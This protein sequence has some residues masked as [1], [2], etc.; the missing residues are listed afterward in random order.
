MKKQNKILVGLVI[1]CVVFLLATLVSVFTQPRERK[2]IS[3]EGLSPEQI[4]QKHLTETYQE[5]NAG[6]TPWN[7]LYFFDTFGERFRL[8]FTWNKRNRVFNAILFHQEKMK[9]IEYLFDDKNDA[10]KKAQKILVQ[11]KYLLRFIDILL[12]QIYKQDPSAGKDLALWA[13]ESFSR[14]TFEMEK[15]FPKYEDD[16]ALLEIQK[17]IQGA[18]NRID[19]FL[20]YDK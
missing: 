8:R 12:P 15:V 5:V 4:I 10:P 11:Q 14:A 3:L 13:N 20:Q 17:N 16:I 18:R 7:P 6:I 9:E 2:P 1:V 19:I